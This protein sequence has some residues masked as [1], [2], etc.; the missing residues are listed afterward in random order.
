M[1]ICDALQVR[2]AGLGAGGEVDCDLLEAVA[3][4]GDGAA[5]L[6][7]HG[8]LGRAAGSDDG[9]GP[10]GFLRLLPGAEAGLDGGG[11][12]AGGVMRRCVLGEGG[13][14]ADALQVAA[15]G[16]D[17]VRAVR[18]V[19]AD[20]FADTGEGG[21]GVSLGGGPQCQRLAGPVGGAAGQCN[22]VGVE[23]AVDLEGAGGAVDPEC[24]VESLSGL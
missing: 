6:L 15:D 16:A 17:V 2:V 14:D 19:G 20:A 5:D 24:A 22:T 4:G 13:E 21:S 11:E 9:V 7:D 1:P 10:E 3:E 8:L 23:A 18:L 12:G